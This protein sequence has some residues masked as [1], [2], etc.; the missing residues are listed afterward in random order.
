MSRASN[1]YCLIQ[2]VLYN[3]DN[4]RCDYTAKGYYYIVLVSTIFPRPKLSKHK[5]KYNFRALHL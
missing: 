2:T 1:E 4:Y 3:A 5:N